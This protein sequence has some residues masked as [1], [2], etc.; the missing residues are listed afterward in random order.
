MIKKNL[1]II[2]MT[3]LC[4]IVPT[5][6]KKNINDPASQV[7][8]DNSG[9]E[10]QNSKLSDD[11]DKSGDRSDNSQNTEAGDPN[12]DCQG[13]EG[14]A[15][16]DDSRGSEGGDRNNSDINSE[17]AAPDN[18][19]KTSE[20]GIIITESAIPESEWQL[21]V[22]FPDWKGEMSSNYSVNNCVG[23]YSYKGQGK[24][25]FECDK[26]ADNFEV[27]VNGSMIDSSP[28]KA[29]GTYAADISAI[30]R[31]G[32][33]ILQVSG[34]ECGNVRVC[35]P[36]PVVIEGKPEDVGLQAG[37]LELIDRIISADIENGFSSAQLAIVK[38]GRLVY[39]HS[40]GNKRTYDENGNFVDSSPVTSDT[41]YD[42]ASN[43]KMYSVNYAIQYMLTRGEI[44][45]N[46]K[47][48]DILG[49]RFSDDTIQIDYEG[50]KK[51][52][53]D[54]NKKW[55]A[56]L[57]I[58]DL[59]RHQGGFPA[60][61]QYYN[62]RYD[63]ATQYYDSDNENVLCV[64]TAG[65][66][67][68]REKTFDAL[69]RTPLMYE[70]GTETLYSDVDYM[71]LCYCIEKITGKPLDEYLA[72]I[73]WEP[74]G[75]GYITYNPLENGFDKESCAA[76]EPMGNSR[77]GNLHYSG[78]R[79]YTLQGEVHDPNAFYCMAGVSGHAGMFSNAVDLAKLASVMLTGGYGDR[80][81][82]S[83]D[84][85][86]LFTAPKSEF[87]PSYGLGWWREGYHKRDYYFGSVTSSTA[88]GHQG[89]TGTLTMIDPENDLVVVFLTNKIHSRLIEN[90]TT[91]NRYRG[92]FYTTA[93]LGFVP[94]IIEMGLCEDPVDES[95]WGALVS[96][97]AT[98]AKRQLEDEGITDEGHPRMKTYKALLSVKS[99]Y[100]R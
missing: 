43:T 52:S 84:V 75:L 48:V 8:S 30:T 80:S 89:F 2:I 6:C 36:F 95:V 1:L 68:A 65:D 12:K 73:F 22:T 64:G 100:G 25:Y 16:G 18:T 76:T 63:N 94:Q 29:G 47:I 28:A 11:P 55:K 27:F 82:F 79:T 90:D 35:I 91:L 74:M 58:R 93:T 67:A 56:G 4:V 92:N 78:V 34:V 20:P 77:D 87:Y 44:D 31:N 81:Y 61:P 69:C 33:N 51:V 53:L 86:D 26:D 3:L 38:D 54:T 14:D 50:Y 23:F 17:T 9:T 46:S 49:S 59:M 85:I 99:G 42:L 62:D 32:I 19:G 40:W 21:D 60:G 24:V 10:N 37:A 13:L 66:A 97:M 15:T 83:R 41:L 7:I 96:D 70:P 57:T 88:Y 45:I 39:E 71:I 5:G 98:D 72:E